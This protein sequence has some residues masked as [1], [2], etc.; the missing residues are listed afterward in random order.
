MSHAIEENR[1]VVLW[2]VKPSNNTQ[3]G[4]VGNG[5][6]AFVVRDLNLLPPMEEEIAAIMGPGAAHANLVGPYNG[7]IQFVRPGFVTIVGGLVKEHY[8]GYIELQG[9]QKVAIAMQVANIAAVE[10]EMAQLPFGLVP[11]EG[12]QFV[13]H[14]PNDYPELGIT[15]CYEVTIE[16]VP[17]AENPEAEMAANAAD[18]AAANDDDDAGLDAMQG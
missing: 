4:H 3:G 16:A 13:L 10:P 12:E 5:R 11:K 7:A 8:F 2:S 6:L 9:D 15:G 14:G 17:A 1:P 18:A